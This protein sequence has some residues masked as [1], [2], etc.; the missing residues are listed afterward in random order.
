MS[1]KG[2]VNANQQRRLA[3]GLRMLRHD[4]GA[5]ASW[6]ELGRTGPAQD[7]IRALVARIIPAVEAL[8]ASLGLPAERPVPPGRRLSAVAEVWAN[9]LADL[10]ARNLRPYGKVHPDLAGALDAK[11]DELIGLLEELADAGAR[12]PPR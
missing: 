11:L 2:L 10:H 7:A 5:I 12:L 8:E 4:V 3:T 6:P 1:G 9:R